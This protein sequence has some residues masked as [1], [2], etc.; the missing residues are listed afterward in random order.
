MIQVLSM[1]EKPQKLDHWSLSLET[2]ITCSLV[3]LPWVYLQH[4]DTFF[5]NSQSTEIY[6]WTYKSDPLNTGLWEI[7]KANSKPR[8]LIREDE[9]QSDR[10]P[11]SEDHVPSVSK[12]LSLSKC[13]RWM[14]NHIS[15]FDTRLAYGMHIYLKVKLEKN[16][17]SSVFWSRSLK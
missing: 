16:T 4:R 13:A 3:T 2:N 5:F 6:I 11:Q 14:M 15:A 8:Y 17:V 9:L 7:C 12:D 1:T 10:T